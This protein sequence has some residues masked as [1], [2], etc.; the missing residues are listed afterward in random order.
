VSLATRLYWVALRTYPADFRQA[1]GE[2]IVST[3]RDC[4]DAGDAHGTFSQALSLAYNGNRLRWMHAT[5]GSVAQTF[6]QGVAWGVVLLVAWQAG[7]ALAGI[8]RPLVHGYTHAYPSPADIA[9]AAG[10]LLALVLLASAR[11]K[12]GLVALG[13]VLAGF[14]ASQVSFALGYGGRF[15]WTFTLQF[16]LPVVLP[17]LCAFLPPKRPVRLPLLV[18]TMVVVVAALVPS[19]TLLYTLP[20][21]SGWAVEAAGCVVI[22]IVVFLASLSDPRWVVMMTLLVFVPLIRE[23]IPELS[24][25][26]GFSSYSGV[27]LLAVLVPLG[28]VTLVLRARRRVATRPTR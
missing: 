24:R 4:H 11:R 22:G 10:W 16:F 7:R 17:L 3:I 15:S 26:G 1:N 5:G 14:V 12:W 25:G 8:G 9:L 28:A 27:L 20:G 13:L 23:F 21:L 2:E 6:R 18:I 19:R